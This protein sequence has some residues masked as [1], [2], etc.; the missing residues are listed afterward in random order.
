MPD[1]CPRGDVHAWNWLSHTFVP[2]FCALVASQT[3]SPIKFGSSCRSWENTLNFKH[4]VTYTQARRIITVSNID[5]VIFF[6]IINVFVLSVSLYYELTTLNAASL[7]TSVS[8]VLDTERLKLEVE[9]LKWRHHSDLFYTDTSLI[10]TLGS[11]SVL[12]GFDCNCV[13]LRIGDGRPWFGV[14]LPQCISNS[15]K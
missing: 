2:C 13:G 11:M 6:L 1:K 15:K 9:S 5:Q 7:K 4:M 12:V 14:A 8:L 10:R 3:N